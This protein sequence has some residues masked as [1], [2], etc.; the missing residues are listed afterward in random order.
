MLKREQMLV[1]GNLLT[2]Y[3]ANCKGLLPLLA[4]GR[5]DTMLRILGER[6]E[7]IDPSLR[8]GQDLLKDTQILLRR[9]QRVKA[10][11]ALVILLKAPDDLFRA[12]VRR[13]NDIALYA[14]HQLRP[15]GSQ[16]VKDAEFQ[17]LGSAFCYDKLQVVTF[18]AS[19]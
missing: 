3:P 5:P 11:E 9:R 17:K 15:V 16:K 6:R 12:V 4:A 19:S 13:G 7:A 10:T 18:G 8:S 14:I 2:S 1:M